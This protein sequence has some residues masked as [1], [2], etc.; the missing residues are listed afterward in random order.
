MLKKIYTKALFAPLVIIILFIIS[1]CNNKAPIPPSATD[2]LTAA[3][4]TPS[5]EPRQQPEKPTYAPA[6][7]ATLRPT[8]TLEPTA[9][10][11]P[12]PMT[13]YDSSTGTTL[14]FSMDPKESPLQPFATSAPHAPEYAISIERETSVDEFGIPTIVYTYL[15]AYDTDIWDVAKKTFV[16][17]GVEYAYTDVQQSQSTTTKTVSRS[18]VCQTAE[19]AGAF[20]KTI[21]YSGIDGNGILEIQPETVAVEVNETTKTPYTVSATKTYT[22]EIKD[23]TQIPNTIKS[24]G[25]TLRLGSVT[26]SDGGD[27]GTAEGAYGTYNTVA[28]T[29]MATANYSAT[30]IDEKSTYKGIVSYAGTILVK[31]SPTNQFIVTYKPG[32][33]IKNKSGEL[34][35]DANDSFYSSQINSIQS[36]APTQAESGLNTGVAQNPAQAG[37]EQQIMV[38]AA[39]QPTTDPPAPTAYEIA[40]VAN[41]PTEVPAATIN[42]AQSE[43]IG[44]NV[45]FL[46]VCGLIC[47][48]ILIGL[49]ILLIYTINKFSKKKR[50]KKRRR[51][52]GARERNS[53]CAYSMG[54][55]GGGE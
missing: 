20:P 49:V 39:S 2:T 4:I 46:F 13:I 26:W 10:P 38:L 53:S 54:D 9:D 8:S 23:E 41:T 21:E 37:G 18:Q 28:R 27:P 17:N 22:M 19:A 45:L 29:W 52:G 35:E 24:Q 16:I 42:S 36:E 44:N 15:L 40:S 55:M 50:K 43:N 47:I 51:T 48:C 32:T 1:S 25:Y 14:T 31:N 11:R 30:A 34:Q 6:P 7:T 33:P 5:P 12:T 3:D